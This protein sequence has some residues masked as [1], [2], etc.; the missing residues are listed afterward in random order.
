MATPK[1]NSGRKSDEELERDAAGR[2]DR[3]EEH[4]GRYRQARRDG[5][6]TV[7]VKTKFPGFSR[8]TFLAVSPLRETRTDRASVPGA[9]EPCWPTLAHPGRG[10]GDPYS[11]EARFAPSAR[12]SS[13]R[14]RAIS[15]L[16]P[17]LPASPKS[18]RCT[19]IIN[20]S[21]RPSAARPAA[22]ISICLARTS[23]AL[24]TL[25]IKALLYNVFSMCDTCMG[26]MS[27]ARETSDCVTASPA[28]PS[29]AVRASVM[30]CRLVRSSAASARSASRW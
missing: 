18:R 3:E 25:V 20:G 5:G 21:A 30:N 7:G 2:G 28:R 22:V 26:W 13:R 1:S 11:R 12:S 15:R 14:R 10:T 6:A 9:R 4:V 16:P 27:P 29:Q 8:A 24:R 23:A 17:G 19:T